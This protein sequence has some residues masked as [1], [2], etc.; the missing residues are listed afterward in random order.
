MR[1]LTIY[2]I[3]CYVLFFTWAWLMDFGAIFKDLYKKGNNYNI[4]QVSS[5][6]NTHPRREHGASP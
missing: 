6:S 1:E 4:Y 3:K 2:N 5:S